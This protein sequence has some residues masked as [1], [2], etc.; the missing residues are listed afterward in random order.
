MDEATFKN[1]VSNILNEEYDDTDIKTVHIWLN[2]LCQKETHWQQQPWWFKERPCKSYSW[3]VHR[4]LYQST[5]KGIL[6]GQ[7]V[8]IDGE[9]Q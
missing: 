1:A 8:P 6:Y 7:E 5:G 4:T 2:S 9:A 3:Q